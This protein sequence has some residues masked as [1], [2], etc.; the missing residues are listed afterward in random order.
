MS[1]SE[2][3]PQKPSRRKSAR[4]LRLDPY[5]F[6][7]SPVR[8]IFF[9]LYLIIDLYSRKVVAWSVHDE[10][11]AEL[12]SALASEACYLEGVDPGEVVLHSDNGA[13][14]K[15]ATMLATLHA[16]GVV[17]SFSRPSVSNDNP[18]SEALFRTLKYRPQYP[19]QA[20][21][22]LAAARAW[23]ERFVRWYNAEHCHSALKFVTPE[24]RH[25]G[26]DA[27]LLARRHDVYQQAKATHPERW[28]GQTRNWTPA[29]A[30]TLP[31]YRP[32]MVTHRNDAKA[33]AA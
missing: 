1:G 2:G 7:R 11:R 14:M 17:A 22:S 30:A 23:V 26:R 4:A 9:Y 29:S 13:S 16:L 31:T 19:E 20:F 33:K 21:E 5:T 25:Q 3:G 12:A 10:E 15:G 18:F 6:M 27:A 28:S 32:K 8:G 24:Q